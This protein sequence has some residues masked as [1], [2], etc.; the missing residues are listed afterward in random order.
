M[1]THGTGSEHERAQL[2]C[3]PAGSVPAVRTAARSAAGTTL[4]RAA[5]EKGLV[6]AEHDPVLIWQAIVNPLHLN[7]ALDGPLDDNTPHARVRVVL[8]LATARPRGTVTCQA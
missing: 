8:H 1:N 2:P 7:A 3:S 6:A 5:Q 4:L